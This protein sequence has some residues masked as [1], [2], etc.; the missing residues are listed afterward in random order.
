VLT[1][2]TREQHIRR[3]RATSNICT[4]S[5][6]TALAATIHLALLGRVGLRELARVNHARGR[7]LRAAMERAGCAR[8]FSGP[9]FNEQAFEVGDAEAV[10]AKLA[11]RGLAAGV[12]LARWFPDDRRLSGA[13]LCVATELHTPELIELF[14][15]AVK[16]A[17]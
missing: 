3:E 14:A 6:L 5:G 1:L 17:R 15:R 10:V 11:Q 13:L 16:E 7:L 4:N 2:S 9:A 12:P 8:V